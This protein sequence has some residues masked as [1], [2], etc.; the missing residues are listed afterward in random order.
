MNASFEDVL[1]LDGILDEHE[2]D[3]LKILEAFQDKRKIDADAIADLAIDNFYEMR[4]K[5]DDKEFV[6]KR[7]LEMQLE[8][9]FPEYYSKYS[10][11]TFKEEI[12]YS[13]A[14][15]KGRKQDEWLLDLCRSGKHKE[16]SLEEVF[17]A[18]QKI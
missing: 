16:M 3:W 1:V 2:G 12:T 6:E 13:E 11:V 14:M 4:D 18:V 5:V 7:K 17:Q 8:K 9:Q 15:N 10:L